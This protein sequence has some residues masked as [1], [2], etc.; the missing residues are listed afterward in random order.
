MELAATQGADHLA[1]EVDKRLT[2]LETLRSKVSW[3]R[4]P[5]FIRDLEALRRLIAERMAELDQSAALDRMWRFMN[6]AGPVNH[7]VRDKHGELDGLFLRAAAD[8][9]RLVG[10]APTDRTA[11]ALADAVSLNPKAWR[12]WTPVILQNVPQTFA[13]SALSAVVGADTPVQADLVRQLADAANDVEAYRATYSP[14]ALL[15]PRIAAEVADRLMTAGRLAEA[16]EI[17]DAAGADVERLNRSQKR[18]QPVDEDWESAGI[19]YLELTGEL[20]AAQAARWASFEAT[21]SVDQAKAFISRLADFDDVEAESRA[22]EYARPISGFSARS[23]FPYGLASGR[24][25]GADD[26]GSP[27]RYPRDAETG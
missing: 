7:R 9:N 24:R 19:R 1:L 18:P 11:E 15:E 21:L 25:G 4:R 14:E 16:G 3:R 23:D 8:L 2:S 13:V 26:R 6:V 10:S 17:L 27:R 22:F 20:A 12:E 5:T